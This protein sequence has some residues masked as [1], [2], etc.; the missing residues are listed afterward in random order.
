MLLKYKKANNK[1]ARGLLSY[2]TVHHKAGALQ[3]IIQNYEE[4]PDWQLYLWKEHDDF[5]GIIGIEL[6]EHTFTVHHAAVIPSYR[7]EGIGHKMVEEVQRLQEPLAMCSSPQ[8]KEFLEKCWNSFY[9]NLVD[10]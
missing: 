10:S 1:V 8:T 2:T 9:P 6:E 3:R 4:H 7:N 5:L